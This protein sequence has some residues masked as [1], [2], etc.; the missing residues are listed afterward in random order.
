MVSV[1]DTYNNIIQNM[2][3]SKYPKLFSCSYK[4]SNII[5]NL[6]NV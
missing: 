6:F 2:S 4:I 5:Q 1:E 3:P